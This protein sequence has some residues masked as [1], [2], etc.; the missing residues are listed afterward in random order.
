MKIVQYS[1][2]LYIWKVSGVYHVSNI[3]LNKS[4]IELPL[5]KSAD[6]FLYIL[7]LA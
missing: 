6:S 7:P 4:D 5:H 3:E 1:V 2:K